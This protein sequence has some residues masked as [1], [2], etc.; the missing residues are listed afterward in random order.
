MKQYSKE[1]IQNQL[2]SILNQYNQTAHLSPTQSQ[3]HIQT[4]YH[5]NPKRFL[6]KDDLTKC[7][8][9]G[10]S[11]FNNLEGSIKRFDEL[12]SDIGETVFSTLGKNVAKGVIK[13]TDGVNG[14]LERHGHF[15]HHSYDN[16][17]YKD[18]FE[19]INSL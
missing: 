9:L 5:K 11:F 19:I 12:K 13:K 18:N 10:L 4:Q 3:S 17:N 16:A 14:Q 8:A 1:E 2:Q 6:N 7:K 15:T